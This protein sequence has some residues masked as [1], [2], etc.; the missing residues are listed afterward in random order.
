MFKK[1]FISRSIFTL[2]NVSSNQS[3]QRK[4]RLCN[5]MY[6]HLSSLLHWQEC[7]TSVD[8]FSRITGFHQGMIQLTYTPTKREKMLHFM[9]PDPHNIS[10][11]LRRNHT[12]F[13]FG[14][15]SAV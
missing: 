10:L 8:L 12:P 11:W 14:V 9:A 7:P 13:Q 3:K 15:I 5:R 1:S 6:M 4:I 2:V